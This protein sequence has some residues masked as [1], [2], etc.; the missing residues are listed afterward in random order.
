MLKNRHRMHVWQGDITTFTG[1]VIVNAA[2]NALGDGSGVNG[3]IQRAAGP[4]MLEFC[5]Q[6]HGCETGQA[7]LTPGFNLP[8]RAVIHAVGPIYQ[9][10][11]GKGGQNKEA[12][13]LASCYR[14]VMKIAADEAFQSMALPAISCGVYAYPPA[15]AVH[16]AVNTVDEALNTMPRMQKVVFCC[17]SD[18]M[19]ELYRAQLK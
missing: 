5:R 8:A 7:K 1:D 16:I 17:F 13:L 19:T 11:N 14:S 10:G 18:E 12:K 9:N 15:E 2:N 3:A 4:Q 6:L